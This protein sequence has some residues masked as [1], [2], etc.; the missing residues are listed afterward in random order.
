MG[1]ND[2][3]LK[4]KYRSNQDVLFE[5]F[6]NPCLTES[7]KYDRAAGYFSSHSLRTMAKGF[8][9]FLHNGGKIRV[10]ANPHLSIQDF[11][12]IEKGH[13]AKLDVIERALL[14]E[15]DVNISSLEHDTLNV[16]AWLIYNDQLEFKIAFAENNSLYHEKFGVFI[17]AKE[18]RVAFSGSSNETAGGVRDNFEKIDVYT[19]HNEK[20]RIDDMI[21]DFDNLWSNK[22]KGLNVIDLPL[23]IKKKMLTYK[24][25]KSNSSNFL[26]PIPRPYQEVAIDALYKNNWHG[27]LEMATGTGKTITSLLASHRFY[28]DKG[29]MFI[30][31]LVPFTHLI[32]QW[33]QE[34]LKFNYNDLTLCFGSRSKW[35]N[36]LENEV[37]DYKI[38]ISDFHLVISTYKT[39][40]TT[41]F[42]NLIESLTGQTFLIADECHYL[43]SLAFK[44]IKIDNFTAKIGLSA[45]PDRWWDEEGTSFIKIFF[46]GIVYKYSLEEAIE[47]KALTNYK[48]LPHVADLSEEELINY[49]KLTAR[50]AFLYSQDDIDK[51]LV[52]R[53]NLERSLIIARA[54]NKTEQLINILTLKKQEEV[55]HTLVYCAPK[56]VNEITKKIS[57]L[58][59]RV[60]RFDSNVRNLDRK[61]ILESF[62]DGRI[63][64]LV[65]IKCL[66]EGVDVPSTRVA[67]FLASTS[68]PREFVQRR[69]RI[70]RNYSGKNFAEIHDFIVLPSNA[71]EKTFKTIATK[72]LPRFAEFSYAALNKYE[73]HK[74]VNSHLE[75]YDLNYLMDM[76][77]WD[78]Y[79]GFGEETK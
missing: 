13:Q 12:A 25:D 23:S 22:T 1:L 11:E 29:R 58:G 26:R 60:H 31:I 50:L 27:I 45:T 15:V 52:D 3:D 43:G 59:I 42:L 57:D 65:A 51:E 38:G 79:K 69:G 32:E 28:K 9:I 33:K 21:C 8:G 18:N 55:S 34:C 62:D 48:Y 24:K 5:D 73:S 46:N 61:T 66:D 44:D 17:D 56:Q 74:I 78:V 75:I 40:G 16:L 37:R 36:R 68:N 67:Y 6:Y 63:Q 49:E 20:L 30:V 35:Y 70:L 19:D 64:V 14:K 76:K 72:E 39:A 10:V 54:A 71:T 47:N 2:L 41:D 77:P 53:L 7:V 4:Y